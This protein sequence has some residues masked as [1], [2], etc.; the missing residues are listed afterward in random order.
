MS[1]QARARLEPVGNQGWEDHKVMFEELRSAAAAEDY[2]ACRMS[3]SGGIGSRWLASTR[4]SGLIAAGCDGRVGV[5]AGSMQARCLQS[6]TV[7]GS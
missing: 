6:R 2:P 5:N 3:Q 1:S 7:S 4:S